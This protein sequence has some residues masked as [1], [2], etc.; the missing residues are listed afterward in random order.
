MLHN[1]TM[2]TAIAFGSVDQRGEDLLGKLLFS[3]HRAHCDELRHQSE[4]LAEGSTA[5]A[6]RGFGTVKDLRVIWHQFRGF[7]EQNTVLVDDSVEK[8]SWQPENLLLV[9]SFKHKRYCDTPAAAVAHEECESK[10]ETLRVLGKYL[11]EM[12]SN[13]RTAASDSAW[14]VRKFLR[15]R[16]F[17]VY[18]QEHKSTAEI[19]T[20]PSI[21][22]ST[23]ERAVEP[24][25]NK[26][27]VSM[28][29]A[30]SN[31]ANHAPKRSREEAGTEGPELVETAAKCR[32]LPSMS[33]RHR[34]PGLSN[35][36]QLAAVELERL[37]CNMCEQAMRYHGRDHQ[38][39]FPFS[40]IAGMPELTRLGICDVRCVREACRMSRHLILSADAA[41]VA[42]APHFSHSLP[43]SPAY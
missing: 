34:Y 41:A 24:E 36:F 4:T 18:L 17:N 6:Q 21:D 23:S 13:L 19:I 29:A 5:T 38:P 14:D 11:D 28:A 16:P 20:E 40:A 32:K 9:P 31:S 39:W 37:V 8:G 2:L 25:P 27:G 3:G 12:L 22:K 30:V 33:A 15:A 42:W 26:P 1:A 35:I 10:D 7:N 43:R